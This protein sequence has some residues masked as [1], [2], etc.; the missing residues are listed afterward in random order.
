[1]ADIGIARRKRSA[2]WL[3]DKPENFCC[4]QVSFHSFRMEETRWELGL[5]FIE[6]EPH[7]DAARCMLRKTPFFVQSSRLTGSMRN[8]VARSRGAEFKLARLS[9]GNIA[10]YK[11]DGRSF[12]TIRTLYII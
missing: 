10:E 7:G 2:N 9:D 12:P 6:D 8:P 4:G 5:A 11:L 1:M 3:R